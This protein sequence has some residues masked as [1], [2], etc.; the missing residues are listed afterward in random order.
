[1]TFPFRKLMLAFTLLAPG[2]LLAQ[3]AQITGRVVD[4]SGA[5]ITNVR[6]SILNTDTGVDRTTVS[7]T[8]GYYSVPLLARGNYRV[9]AQLAGFKEVVRKGLSLDEGQTLRLDITLEVGQVSERIEV[10]GSAPLLETES[11]TLSTVITN[12]KILDLPTVGRN[13]LQFALLV[14]GVRTVGSYGDLPVSAFGGGRA[15]I[16]GGASGVNNYMVDGIAS[17]NFTSGSLQT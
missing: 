12:Q 2:L 1:M 4:P 17:E 7:N 15:S 9:S 14:P 13:P 3:N 8:E 11:P 6:L 5:I 16:A 10:S